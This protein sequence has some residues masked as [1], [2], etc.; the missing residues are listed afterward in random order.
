MNRLQSAPQEVLDQFGKEKDQFGL[1]VTLFGL[2]R[3]R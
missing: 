3:A 2:K 1:Y